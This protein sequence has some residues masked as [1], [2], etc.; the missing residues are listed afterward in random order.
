[1]SGLDPE[2]SWWSA[3]I[4]FAPAARP[5]EWQTIDLT[6]F[7]LLKVYTRAYLDPRKKGAPIGAPLP[8]DVRFEDDNILPDRCLHRS[9]SWSR[10]PIMATQWSRPNTMNLSEDFNWGANAFW[11]QSSPVIRT[12]ILQ[13]TFGQDGNVADC[14]GYVEIQRIELHMALLNPQGD[15]PSRTIRG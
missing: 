2:N 1:V 12:K 15:D 8:I 11:T 3:V 13:I 5:P 6:K 10:Q 4:G 14:E 9:S 7:S